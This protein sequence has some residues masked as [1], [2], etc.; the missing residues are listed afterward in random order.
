MSP[1]PQHG[2]PEGDATIAIRQLARQTGADVQ[3]LQTLYVLEALLARIA[4]SDHRDDFVLK[5]GVLLAAFAVRRPTKDIDLQATGLANDVD[6]VTARVRQIAALD[7][8]DGVLFDTESIK[9]SVIRDDDE[10]AGIRVRLVGV[11]GH[12]KL[13]IG[14]DVNFGDPI[15]PPPSLVEL[16]R[17][18]ELG[19][20]PVTL[21]GYPLT[22]VLAEKIVT[23]I[24]RGEANTRWRDFA[25]VYTL[26][27]ARPVDAAEF[28]ASLTVVAEYRHVELRPLLPFLAPMPQRAQEKWLAWRR[29]TG[30][31]QELPERFAD[32][33]ESLAWFADAVLAGSTVGRWNSQTEQWQ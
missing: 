26:V 18:V 27:R 2:T 29:R 25:D 12:A 4:V 9:A 28:A 19:Q 16:P 31:E 15:W 24:D 22:M 17:V 32:V 1:N 7:L 23:A 21:L 10:Y 5:G 6:E 13:T 30:R 3:D 8:A 33:L 11:L 20:P 14:I